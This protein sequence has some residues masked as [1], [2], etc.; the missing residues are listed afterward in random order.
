MVLLCVVFCR[1]CRFVYRIFF[2]RLCFFVDGWDCC[3]VVCFLVM[4]YFSN[5]YLRRIFLNVFLALVDRVLK[6]CRGV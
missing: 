5:C 6:R 4:C 2:L 3:C 1:L